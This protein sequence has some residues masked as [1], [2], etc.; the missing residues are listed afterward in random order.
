MRS[1]LL[2]GVGGQGTVLASRLIAQAAMNQGDFARTAET[3]GMAQRGG[4]VVSH[5]RWGEAVASPLIPLRC[6]DALIGFEPGEAV[7]CLPYLKK[8]GW[9][10]VSADPVPS[11][12]AALGTSEYEGAA[13]VAFLRKAVPHLVVLDGAAIAKACGSA[14]TLNLA[15]LGAATACGALDLGADAL[16]AVLAERM[17]PQL[18]EM[19]RRAFEMGAKQAK[20]ALASC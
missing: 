1:C 4:C 5:V 16:L 20:E 7:R 9:A 19:N 8:D 17:K 2:C 11:V 15:L 18:L 12:M 6:A 13:M 10:V 14:K 3:I